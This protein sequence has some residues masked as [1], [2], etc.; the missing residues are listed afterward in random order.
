MRKEA[1]MERSA[2]GILKPV[3]IGGAIFGFL[4]GAPFVGI[5]N[6]A[7][8][9]LIVGAGFVATMLY[10][11]Q[12]VA[13]GVPFT[14]AVGAKVGLAAGVVYAVF[15]TLTSTVSALLFK[16]ATLE[17]VVKMLDQ[18]PNV[19]PEVVEQFTTPSQSSLAAS[20]LFGFLLTL[21]L[22]VIFATLGGLVAGAVF[23]SEPRGPSEPMQT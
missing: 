13:L 5:L 4:G 15:D 14:P 12:C 20:V 2:P 3:L 11:K 23:K 7:C 22:G 6:C 19:P 10:S 9:A 17:W 21:G 8:C 18:I 16:E 1:A